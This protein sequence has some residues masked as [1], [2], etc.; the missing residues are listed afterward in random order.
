MWMKKWLFYYKKRYNK[1][2]DGYG[3]KLENIVES[4]QFI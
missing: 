1:N 2:W 4:N 3:F